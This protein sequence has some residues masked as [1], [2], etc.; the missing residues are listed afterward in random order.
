MQRKRPAAESTACFLIPLACACPLY[1]NDHV[2]RIFRHVKGRE[3]SSG[4][5]WLIFKSQIL[6]GLEFQDPKCR[7]PGTPQPTVSRIAVPTFN[8]YRDW[9]LNGTKAFV[10]TEILLILKCCS[11]MNVH[12]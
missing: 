9:I 5:R 1:G 3:G 4:E 2:M 11:Q 12:M 7:Q 10:G 6:L 8:I